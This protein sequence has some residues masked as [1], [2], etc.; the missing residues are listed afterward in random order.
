MSRLTLSALLAAIL[1]SYHAVYASYASPSAIY[2]RE[3]NSTSALLNSANFTFPIPFDPRDPHFADSFAN[4]VGVV[5]LRV[6]KRVFENKMPFAHIFSAR[7]NDT[8]RTF[9]S[10]SSFFKLR[11]L[12]GRLFFRDQC[13]LNGTDIGINW[14][15]CPNGDVSG[16][17]VRVS[18]YLANLLLGIIVMFSPEDASEGV[19]TQ[20]LTVYSLLISGI[21]AIGSQSLSRFHAGQTIFLVMSPLSATLVVYAVLGFL[22]RPHR[23]DSILSNSRQHLLPR[24]LVIVFWLIAM[25]FLIFTSISKD[26]HFTKVSPCDDLVDKGAGAALEYSLIFVPYVGVAIVILVIIA[27]FGDGYAT[28]PVAI[29]ACAPFILLVIALVCVIIKS[30]HSLAEQFRIQNN[31]WKIWVVWDFSR[32]RHPFL[33]FC[34]VF[35]VPMIYWVIVNELR[36]SGTPDNLFSPSFG[37]VLALFV[38]LQ[39]LLQVAPARVCPA[40]VFACGKSG[41]GFIQ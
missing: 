25:A 19:W 20:L 30:R 26:S 15:R 37:Q 14:G 4:W 27:N 28:G 41:N 6:S 1:V 24:T 3:G 36:L 5:C 34:G 35:L 31:R 8:V 32:D 17:L 13:Y 9:A 12:F 23:L 40:G 18:T 11:L 33:H 22:G 21:I 16:I 10:P 7:P 39:P 38:V 2:P 29:G